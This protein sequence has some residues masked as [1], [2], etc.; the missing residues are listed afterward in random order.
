MKAGGT[1][2]PGSTPWRLYS[3]AWAPGRCARS[4]CS[5]RCASH[6]LQDAPRPVAKKPRWVG[7]HPQRV[8]HPSSFQDSF[9]HLCFCC[10]CLC[11]PHYRCHRCFC[12]RCLCSPTTTATAAAAAA[13]SVLPNAAVTAGSATTASAF[14]NAAFTAA[15][16]AVS[17]PMLLSLLLMLQALRGL[18]HCL[19]ASNCA[20]C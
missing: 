19:P 6:R 3:P 12:C 8:G 5:K 7:A 17:S 13:A 14:P 11:F 2:Q 10:R 18:L 4:S 20:P 16:A 1:L 15:V 9:Q